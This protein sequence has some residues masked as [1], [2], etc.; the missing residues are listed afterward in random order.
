M[1]TVRMT[2]RAVTASL[3]LGLLLGFAPPAPALAAS[4]TSARSGGAYLTVVMG[5]TAHAVVDTNCT[6]IPNAVPL[7]DVA[8]AF[9]GVG[10]K[11]TGAVVTDWVS[12]GSIQCHNGAAYPPWSELATLRDSY[13]WSFFSEGSDHADV[14]SMSRAQQYAYACGSLQTLQAHGHNRAWG[15]FAYPGGSPS[16][17]MQVAVTQRCYAYGRTYRRSLNTPSAVGR[18][19]YFQD[20]KQV[21]GGSCQD[22]SLPCYGGSTRHRYMPVSTL[23]SY[24]RP[25]A[26]QWGSIQAYKF[27]TG[28]YA[29]KSADGPKWDCSAADWRAHWTNATELYCLNDFLT[30]AR[31][32]P[33]SVTVTDPAGVA[34]AW[35]PHP[36]APS[37]TII[38][39]P[40]SGRTANF[41]FRASD[42]RSWFQCFL[43]H[44][45]AKLCDSGVSF[46]AVGAGRHTFSVRAISAYGVTGPIVSRSFTGG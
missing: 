43:D 12:D 3:V 36:Q 34:Q 33:A 38:G 4:A 41:T 35:S 39:G 37:T 32:I 31:T 46:P 23:E 10:L 27:V 42:S 1:T 21:V 6:T 16:Q 30:A 13:G 2:R 15:M 45:A 28:S 8:K 20:T 19:P 5:R 7:L 25:A 22:R 18:P 24:M 9:R 14:S 29:S 26:G 17:N 44:A 40:G 11:A